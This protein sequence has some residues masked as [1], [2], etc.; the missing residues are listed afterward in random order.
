MI[1]GEN[2]YANWL[3]LA[4]TTNNE[5]ET[6]DS[7]G[8]VMILQVW[9]RQRALQLMYEDKLFDIVIVTTSTNASVKPDRDS[10]FIATIPIPNPLLDHDA[11]S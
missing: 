5:A 4:S 8:T 11:R 9:R 2:P 6:D 10:S 7:V 3:L 1:D